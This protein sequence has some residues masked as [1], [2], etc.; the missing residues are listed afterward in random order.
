MT[1]TYAIE[2]G[3]EIVILALILAGVFNEEKIAKWEKKFF[4][5]LKKTISTRKSQP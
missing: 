4:S 1:Q 5:K 3:I 2:S